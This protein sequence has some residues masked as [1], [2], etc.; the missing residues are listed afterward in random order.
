MIGDLN[1]TKAVIEI[2]FDDG[3]FST[4]GQIEFTQSYNASPIEISNKSYLDYVTYLDE[5]LS[6]IQFN[7]SGNII[8]NSDLTY[9]RLRS[10]A[11]LGQLFNLR[12]IN[13]K[14]NS[15]I[16]EYKAIVSNM[17]DNAQIG[18]AVSTS[19]TFLSTFVDES[20]AKGLMKIT[21]T[22]DGIG[23]SSIDPIFSQ[24][25]LSNDAFIDDYGVI[26]EIKCTKTNTFNSPYYFQFRVNPILA[27]G[28]TP[29]S[30]KIVIGEQTIFVRSGE[31]FGDGNDIFYWTGNPNG[32]IWSS[33]SEADKTY[34][35]KPL[36]PA[37]GSEILFNYLTDNFNNGDEVAYNIFPQK[38]DL[39]LIDNILTPGEIINGSGGRKIG[40]SIPDNFGSFSKNY[41]S[42]IQ[43]TEIDEF[44]ITKNSDESLGNFAIVVGDA[45]RGGF[46]GF[47]LNIDNQTYV[48]NPFSAN[49]QFI[50]ST[51]NEVKQKIFDQIDTAISLSK[52]LKISLQACPPVGGL[53]AILSE[54]EESLG[55]KK[56]GYEYFINQNDY[57][58]FNPAPKSNITDFQDFEKFLCIVD[59]TN[60]LG[61]ITINF[62]P[63]NTGGSN[64][65]FS[66][67]GDEFTVL[68]VTLDNTIEYVI[69]IKEQNNGS[70]D[71]NEYFLDD[72]EIA[73]NLMNYLEDAA[74]EGRQIITHCH[75]DN[76]EKFINK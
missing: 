58:S 35:D 64:F 71:V 34:P 37:T 47:L 54:T 11:N 45:V 65:F 19:I 9:R 60:S 7:L 23:F 69:P 61:S 70:F 3:F 33:F 62:I 43:S 38:P 74:A 42:E 56:V 24:S 40:F 48:I 55:I 4:I 1:G 18:S 28:L 21:K 13:I 12:I 32:S 73:R 36:A 75:V 29:K 26:T 27:G 15:I 46:R 14:N 2:D 17:D 6:S 68:R 5:G 52:T 59:N 16:S 20:I 57:G 67:R 31:V 22:V 51:F 8:Y 10:F 39:K 53:G 41:Y 72:F 44:Y 25:E 49:R 76:S 50:L 30:L 66:P 63:E